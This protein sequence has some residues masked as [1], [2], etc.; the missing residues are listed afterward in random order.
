MK[1]SILWASLFITLLVLSGCGNKNI[2]N[3]DP[4]E[5]LDNPIVTTWDAEDFNMIVWGSRYSEVED[6]ISLF[7]F[8]G[9]NTF[10]VSVWGKDARGPWIVSE[11]KILLGESNLELVIV[12][13]NEIT[14]DGIQYLRNEEIN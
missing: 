11:G 9:D 12:G 4:L 10:A 8:K 6:Q 7:T 14:I 5:I 13:E 1:K 3:A 2:E